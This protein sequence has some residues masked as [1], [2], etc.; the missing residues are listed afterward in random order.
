MSHTKNSHVR[1]NVL[2]F[3]LSKV[4]VMDMVVVLEVGV[5]T[6]TPNHCF[7]LLLT[8]AHKHFPH[9]AE[10]GDPRLHHGYCYD[11]SWSLWRKLRMG[12]CGVLAGLPGSW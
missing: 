3:W 2:R 1:D 5:G 12:V 8:Y 9:P 4:R 11:L 10:V 6:K 7:S